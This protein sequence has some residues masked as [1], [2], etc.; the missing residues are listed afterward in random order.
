M[1]KRRNLV[2]SD[3]LRQGYGDHAISMISVLSLTLASGT[4]SVSGGLLHCT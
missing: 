4:D 1:E 2:L 3:F